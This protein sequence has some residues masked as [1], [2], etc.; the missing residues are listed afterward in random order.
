MLKGVGFKIQVRADC[1]KGSHILSSSIDRELGSTNRESQKSDF[2][3]CLNKAQAHK[4][5]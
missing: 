5:V 1:K 2:A 4:N 3:K